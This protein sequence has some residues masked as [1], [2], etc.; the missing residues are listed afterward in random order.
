VRDCLWCLSKVSL[1]GASCLRL[2]G[3]DLVIR[4]GTTAVLGPSGAGKSSLLNLL[5][6][7]ERPSDG[8]LHV[9]EA[10]RGN[11][12]WVPQTFGLWSHLTAA[13]HVR[14]ALP[15]GA[16]VNE[17]RQWLE[18]VG[19]G[20]RSGSRPDTLS[21]GEKA[22]LAVARA[23]ATG[24]RV[25]V[26]DEPLVCV[27]AA[28]QEQC[29]GLIRD[30]AV[31]ATG[32]VFATHSPERVRSEADHVVIMREGRVAASGAVPELYDDPP[33]RFVAEALGPANWFE[34]R[35]CGV[36]FERPATD[37][38]VCVRP[39][40]L[41]LCPDPLGPVRVVH[42]RSLGLLDRTLAR[43]ERTGDE[44]TFLH[45]RRSVLASGDRVR[46]ESR[47]PAV[48]GVGSGRG[49]AAG[50]ALTLLLLSLFL[51]WGCGPVGTAP[52]EPASVTTWSMPAAGPRIPGPRGVAV[53]PDGSIYTV[54]TLGRILVF[55]PQGRV[56]R[57]WWMPETESGCPE[58][59]TVLRSG[60]VAVPDTHYSRVLFF[61]PDGTL[62]WS[63][64]ETGREPGRFLYPVAL[65]EDDD[66]C[67][68]VCE[69]GSNDRVQK[70]RADGEFLLAFGAFGSGPGQFQRPA[71]IVWRGGRVYVADAGNGCVHVFGDSGEL[72]GLVET[73][74]GS[75]PL[76]FPYDVDVDDQGRF[77]VVE[78]GGARVRC[79]DP[80]AETVRVWGTPGR[81]RT[82]L[83]TPWGIA[84][85]DG[86]VY[87]ADTANS[88]LVE[89]AL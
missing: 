2:R 14:L 84:C 37:G 31:N 77:W 39:E 72:L 88:R 83:M 46:L 44:R 30:W 5:V 18:R 8:A 29:W 17:V 80:V 55:S 51:V 1:G 52:L 76:D 7:Y 65:A 42:T 61:E 67:L 81:G 54:D 6:E 32:L 3:L 25:L 87:V 43:A 75:V 12:Y 79:C 74:G 47:R 40:H 35:E 86:V 64:G 66:G 71:G 58:D 69:Y 26:M 24:A 19:L 53:G 33:D 57:E 85:G 38:Q 4:P 13:D 41:V 21:E 49:G 15:T 56:L 62:A 82:S 63:L 89:I 10:V 28:M 45:V 60:Q 34:S 20:H 23:L 9:G 36:W 11:T 50:S 78:W 22:R 70:F 68:Y 48:A 73:E 27:D 59:L 16:D